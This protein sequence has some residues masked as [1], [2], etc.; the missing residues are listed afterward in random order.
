MFSMSLY[1]II[2]S[3]F[4]SSSLLS[5]SA[6]LPLILADSSLIGGYDVVGVAVAVVDDGVA[7][8][9]CCR[10]VP[11]KVDV[12]GELLFIVDLFDW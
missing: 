10:L 7:L 4:H 6:H 9:D 2:V 5:S 11:I 1:I 12:L 3:Y 8:L